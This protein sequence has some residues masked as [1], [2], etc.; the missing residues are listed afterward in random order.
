MADRE[1]AQGGF[2][3]NPQRTAKSIRRVLRGRL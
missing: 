3:E 2:R 1:T